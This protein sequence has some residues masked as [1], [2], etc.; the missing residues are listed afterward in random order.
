MIVLDASVMI[1]VLD[2]RDV[3]HAAA[4]R[5]FD[6]NAAE[7]LAAHRLTA[8][9][10][11]VQPARAGRVAAVSAALITLGVEWVD[12]L[13]D[14]AELAELRARTGLREPD[15]CVLLAAR[16]AGARLATF[17]ARLASAARGEG[18]PVVEPDFRSGT[19]S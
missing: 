2:R 1:A 7:R 19:A 10:S 6:E 5:L 12:I 4:R 3:H 16:R 11:L 18:V 14:P 17:D 15:A 9:E 13:D 8:A